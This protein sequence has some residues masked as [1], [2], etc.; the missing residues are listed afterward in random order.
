M[1][2]CIR[3][4]FPGGVSGTV[5]YALGEGLQFA[6]V[7]AL[8]VSFGLGLSA[9]IH[10][11]NRLRL[12]GR[13]GVSPELAV[14]RRHRAGRSALI[15][16]RCAGLRSGGNGVFDLPSLRLFAGSARLQW[17]RPDSRPFILRPT[18]M[19]LIN[20]ERRLRGTAGRAKP[21]E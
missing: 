3:R 17:L 16:P 1:L 12:A 7:V 19:F 14:E 9:T 11:L 10:F 4:H 6:S 5:L 15:S 2:S 21:A 13:A 20:L 18:A 8:T